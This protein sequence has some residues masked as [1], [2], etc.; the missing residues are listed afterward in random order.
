MRKISFN[1]KYIA[2]ALLAISIGSCD[3]LLDDS[4]TDYGKGPNLVGFDKGTAIIKAEAN[5]QEL[6]SEIPVSIIGPTVPSL[7]GDAV[8][9]TVSVDPSS[10]AVEGVNYRLSSNTVTL[11]PDGGDKYVGALPIIIITEGV[12]TPVDAAPVLILSISEVSSDKELVVNDKTKKVAATIAYT[13]P[14]DINDYEGTYLATVDDFGIY[15]AGPQPFEVVV[16][17]GENQLT[18]KNVA[19]HPEGFNLVVDVD[20]ANGDLT[21]PKQEVLNTNNIGYS[22]G[23]MSWEGTGTSGPSPGF[24]AGILDMTN[25]YTVAAGLFGEFQTVFEKQK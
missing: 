16:G 23:V 1:L 21:I 22:Y 8:T 20:P 9:V 11:T 15:I 19:G 18:L 17:P 10:T 2:V 5:G 6:A 25:A 14:Y 7:K 4:V 3:A 24:C 12:E 13:C